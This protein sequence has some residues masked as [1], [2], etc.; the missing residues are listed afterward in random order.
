[1]ADWSNSHFLQALG[2]ATLNSFW[3]MALLWCIFQLL[4]HFA[5]F[6]S[7]QKYLLAVSNVFVGFVWFLLSFSIYYKSGFNDTALS[8]LSV[9]LA[10]DK[11]SII[12][13]CASLTYL[14]L[15]IVP[16]VK[17]MRNW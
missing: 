11:L 1:M 3:Q 6:T 16:T 2:W 13:S 12:L 10:S 14:L 15:L 7:N 8:S 4:T 5:K 17:I 9:E